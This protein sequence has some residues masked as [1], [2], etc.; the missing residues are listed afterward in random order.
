VTFPDY[1]L[2]LENGAIGDQFG[3][4]ASTTGQPAKGGVVSGVW[5]TQITVG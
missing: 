5:R 2:L 1:S 4:T 3:G